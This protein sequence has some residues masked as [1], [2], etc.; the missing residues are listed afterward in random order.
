MEKTEKNIRLLARMNEIYMQNGMSPL[1]DEDKL[2]GSDAAY[3]TQAGI[4]CVESM[5]VHGGTWHSKNEFAYR[6]S[7]K[8][9]AKRLAVATYYL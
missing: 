9:A 8:E 7:L 6:V 3:I 1:Q 5:G 4:P 2:G